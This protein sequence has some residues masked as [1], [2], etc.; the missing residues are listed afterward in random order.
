MLKYFVGLFKVSLDV[1]FPALKIPLKTKIA[2]PYNVNKINRLKIFK[3]IE[4]SI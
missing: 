1:Y 3:Y 4:Y 2:I